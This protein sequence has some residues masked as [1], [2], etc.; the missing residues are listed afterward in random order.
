MSVSARQRGEILGFLGPNG[1]G[2]TTTMRILTGYMPA[3]EK[4]AFVAG[5]DVFANPFGLESGGLGYLRSRTPA[6]P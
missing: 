1:A 4:K 2:K 5:F 3:S 6:L